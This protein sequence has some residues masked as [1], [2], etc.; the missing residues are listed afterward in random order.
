[1]ILNCLS[2]V[3]VDTGIVVSTTRQVK[4]SGYRVLFVAFNVS[5]RFEG[6]V[7]SS[8]HLTFHRET[9]FRKASRSPLRS[10]SY[11]WKMESSWSR[12]SSGRRLGMRYWALNLSLLDTARANFRLWRAAKAD[13]FSKKYYGMMYDLGYMIYKVFSVVIIR[14]GERGWISNHIFFTKNFFL[15]KIMWIQLRTRV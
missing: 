5:V 11:S 10:P 12:L 4:M 7:P 8:S 14:S 2:A 9:S 3:A 6:F 1:M 15:V 13:N